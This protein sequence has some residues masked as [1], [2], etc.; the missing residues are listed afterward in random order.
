MTNATKACH[1]CLAVSAERW[2]GHAEMHEG[3]Q[4]HNLAPADY[5]ADGE[6]MKS[7]LPA[8]ESICKE[9]ELRRLGKGG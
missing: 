3:R 1:N 8:V 4:V 2:S 5:S 9:M 6:L 7:L